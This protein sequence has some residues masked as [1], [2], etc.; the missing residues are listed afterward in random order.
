M[1]ASSD[2]FMQIL[3]LS[4]NQNTTIF[5]FFRARR[6][7]AAR[8]LL[9]TATMVASFAASAQLPPPALR[10]YAYVSESEIGRAHV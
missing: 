1:W 6:A 3:M 7:W 5:E 4:S 8:L 2:L 10:S 9:A